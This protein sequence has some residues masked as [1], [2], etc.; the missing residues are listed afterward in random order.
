MGS[1]AIPVTNLYEF[2]R[3]LPWSVTC[4]ILIVERKSR[5]RTF[6]PSCMPI[7]F[8][9]MVFAVFQR[10]QHPALVP[11]CVVRLH[12]HVITCFVGYAR[13]RRLRRRAVML[14]AEGTSGEAKISQGVVVFCACKYSTSWF[15]R[16]SSRESVPD[17]GIITGAAWANYAWGTYWSWDP[18]ETWS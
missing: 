4:S 16:R 10:Q 6:A 13:L 2:A 3:L 18:K 12:A 15:Y 11:P 14:P 7:A 8:F 5:N 1:G 17:R 9:T